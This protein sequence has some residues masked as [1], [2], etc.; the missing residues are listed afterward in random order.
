MKFHHLFLHFVFF[1]FSFFIYCVPTPQNLKKNLHAFHHKLPVF[2]LRST[3]A[4]TS[5]NLVDMR[6]H[7]ESPPWTAPACTQ[8]S[9]SSTP[10]I[11]S[12]PTLYHPQC[13]TLEPH[14]CT[15]QQAMAPLNFTIPR[16]SFQPLSLSHLYR[17]P[18]LPPRQTAPP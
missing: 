9:P 6:N 3:D 7:P 18:P 17:E 2:R 14:P 1:C 12:I 10:P 11:H 8:L 15:K 5:P 4:L 16:Q 13:Q